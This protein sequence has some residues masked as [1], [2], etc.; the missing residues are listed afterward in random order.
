MN[1]G[2][3]YSGSSRRH[4]KELRARSSSGE[5]QVSISKQQDPS[6][7][8]SHVS[9]NAGHEEKTGRRNAVE[10]LFR[11]VCITSEGINFGGSDVE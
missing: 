5:G 1:A 11:R 3:G 6:A 2:K 4:L 9:R 10:D 8:H 7:F